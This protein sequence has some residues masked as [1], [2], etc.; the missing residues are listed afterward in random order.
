MKLVSNYD[1]G[2]GRPSLEV[3]G[4]TATGAT[5]MISNVSVIA[6]FFCLLSLVDYLT[7]INL[8]SLSILNFNPLVIS[9]TSNIFERFA[10]RGSLPL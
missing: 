9:S 5:L 3:M 8:L 10:F 7:S 4:K 2:F 1:I 6:D